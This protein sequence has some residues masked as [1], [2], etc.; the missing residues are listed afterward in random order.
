MSLPFVNPLNVPFPN[1]LVSLGLFLFARSPPG[2]FS[3][4]GVRTGE[5]CIGEDPIA[6]DPI[7]DGLNWADLNEGVLNCGD[8]VPLSTPDVSMGLV[9]SSFL[10]NIGPILDD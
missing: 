2:S 10:L 4:S 9:S 3:C 7:G 8:R 1:P 5:D 6:G